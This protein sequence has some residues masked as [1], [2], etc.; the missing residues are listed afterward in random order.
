MTKEKLIKTFEAIRD[1]PY[2]IPL[3]IEEEDNCCSGKHQRLCEILEQAGYEVRWAM[4]T[5]KWSSIDLPEKVAS[6]PHDDDSTHVC[7]EVKLGGEW[8]VVDATWDK[9]IGEVF[10][11]NEWDGESATEIAIIPTETFSPERSYYMMKEESG[12]EFV[13]KD[14]EVNGAF[15]KA[16][17]KWLEALRS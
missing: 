1:V 12:D 2:A 3:S 10:H 9:G 17:N 11:V 13:L 15:Y 4:F 16:F 14:L 8:K 6:V 7:L 5:F